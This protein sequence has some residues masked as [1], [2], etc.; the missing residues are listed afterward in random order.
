MVPHTWKRFD[1]VGWQSA[2]HLRI[3]SDA[4]LVER[5]EL[6]RELYHRY[7]GL[8]IGIQVASEGVLAF[9]DIVHVSSRHA[10]IV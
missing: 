7:H 3:D 8:L 5:V 6:P 4:I 2:H 1:V 10:E 9:V